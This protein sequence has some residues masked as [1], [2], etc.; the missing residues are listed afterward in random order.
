MRAKRQEERGGQ[1]F[2]GFVEL[3]AMKTIEQ[4]TKDQRIS[5]ALKFQPHFKY[6]HKLKK[7]S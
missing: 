2:L 3:E 5:K 1:M 7:M 4:P 6:S